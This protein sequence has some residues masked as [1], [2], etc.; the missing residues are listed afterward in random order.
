M[1]KSLNNIF[2]ILM[3]YGSILSAVEVNKSDREHKLY[4]ASNSSEAVMSFSHW[5]E[6]KS[7]STPTSDTVR[8][9]IEKQLSHLFGPMSAQKY[10]SV[11]KGDHKLRVYKPQ[12]LDEDTYRI[13]YNYKGTVVIKNGPSQY[14]D[15][16]LPNNPDEIYQ[17]GMVGSTNP[18]TDHHYQSEGDFW[19]FWNP[20][21]YRCPLKEGQDY[22]R[23]KTKIVRK[24][25][26]ISSFP[27]YARLIRK[28]SEGLQ[29]IKINVFIGM[30]NPSN[31]KNPY[32]TNVSKK[33]INAQT[34][35]TLHDYF[36][37]QG[38]SVVEE[39]DLSHHPALKTLNARSIGYLETQQKKI[40]GPR[41]EIVISAEMYFGPTGINENSRTFHY[42]LKNAIENGSLFIYDGH[43]GLGGH[44]NIESIEYDE[45]Q[46]NPQF[47][48]N[49][50]TNEYQIFYFN[51][52]SSYPYYNTMYFERKKTMSDP[53]G[54]YN[55]DI[56]TNGLSTYFD[57]LDRAS[58]SVVTAIEYWAQGKATVSYQELAKAI[59]S[60]N[61]FGINGDEDNPITP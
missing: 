36:Q 46:L 39:M 21:Q 15:V 51:S 22:A 11:P 9:Q 34:F 20:S 58:L 42:L 17:K 56:L 40:K 44:L 37:R 45:Q 24:P 23:I 31:D 6:I 32:T 5:V 48:I 59:D 3:C 49:F 43:S 38:Y 19:Y 33:D 41:G 54:T 10:Y 2:A 18:C 35:Q 8:E 47:E 52:C 14:Y 30:D 13:K 4:T 16:F 55:L 28:N 26:K 7:N 25:N 29:E 27:D 12:K 53:L 57:V 60:G 61:L 50:N 1:R